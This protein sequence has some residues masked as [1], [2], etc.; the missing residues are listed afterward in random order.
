M[1]EFVAEISD[2][3]PHVVVVAGELD[4]AVADAFLDRCRQALAGAGDTIELDLGGVTFID[5][6][7]IGALVRVHREATAQGTS[8]RLTHVPRQVSRVLDLSG[9]AR[10]FAES[11]GT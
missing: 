11:Q 1:S 5:S 9:L 2:A 3:S 4:I 8:V 10:L 7:G 6:T